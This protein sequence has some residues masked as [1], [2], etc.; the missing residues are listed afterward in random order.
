MATVYSNDT[1]IK[2]F[3]Y[4]WLIRFAELHPFIHDLDKDLPNDLVLCLR[5][6][7]MNI[8]CNE[9]ELN[10]NFTAIFQPAYSVYA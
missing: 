6:K 9:E 4:D 2:R 8:V 10:R 1:A 7:Q 5:Y 3:T